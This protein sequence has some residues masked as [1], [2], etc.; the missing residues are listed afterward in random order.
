MRRTLITQFLALLMITAL[1]LVVRAVADQSA[2][3][4]LLET[5]PGLLNAASSL[6]LLLIGAWFAGQICSAISIPRITGYIVFGLIAGPDI[7]NIVRKDQFVYLRTVNDLAIALIALTAGGEIRISFLKLQARAV[8]FVM[9]FQ[10]TLVGVGV[11]IVMSFFPGSL[12][13][14]ES[15]PSSA[16][17]AA[18]ILLATVCTASSPAVLVAVI[19]ESRATGFMSQVAIA[20]TVVKDLLL[21]IVFTVVIATTSSWLGVSGADAGHGAHGGGGGS[22]VWSLS[23]TLGGSLVAGV[24]FGIGLAWC[25]RRLRR[26]LPIVVV[27][28]CFGMAL[29]SQTLHFEALLVALIAG[30]LME[31]VWG[32]ESEH[33]F[34]TIE[35]LSLPVFCVFFAVAGTKIDLQAL[36][37][38]WDETVALV[39]IR[40]GFT[41]VGCWLGIRAA[42]ARHERGARWMWTAFLP[43]AGVALVFVSI[44]ERTFT[45]FEFAATLYSLVLGMIAIE[46]LLGPVLL[47]FGLQRAGEIQ[48]QGPA[49]TDRA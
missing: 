29:V 3:V 32:E 14:L 37:S 47:R 9:F 18:A 5:D 17:V 24:L 22:L 33:L 42:G 27:L 12:G 16:R 21:V 31:N 10:M 19:S 45:E 13:V 4:A 46:E 1:V 41:W 36:A 23:K 30:V 8:A 2:A 40:A 34:K 43:Q 38:L 7:L 44:I 35:E 20:A 49:G 15:D 25:T 39:L 11:A 26:H 48:G 6:G 28:S